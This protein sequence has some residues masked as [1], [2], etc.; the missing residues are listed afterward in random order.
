MHNSGFTLGRASQFPGG[1]RTAYPNRAAPRGKEGYGLP[2]PYALRC[3][4]V[5]VVAMGFSAQRLPGVVGPEAVT[6]IAA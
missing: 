4:A 6:G 5:G 1:T 3:A 2:P